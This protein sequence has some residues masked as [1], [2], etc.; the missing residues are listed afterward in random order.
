MPT[1]QEII[2]YYQSSQWLYRLFC[3]NSQS[4]GMHYG[5]WEPDTKNRQQAIVNENDVII[6]YGH[7]KK[8]HRVLDAGCG[9][10]GTAIHIAKTTGARV[11]G[12]TLDSK[13]VALAFHYAK[14]AG[15]AHLVEFFVMDYETMRF[16]D[17]SFDVVYGDESIGYAV[18]KAAFL[19]QAYRVLK[20]GGRLVISDGYAARTPRSS[21]EHATERAIKWGFF[22][23]SI[24]T[25]R[26]MTQAI[27][28][29]GFA[30]VQV[31]DKTQE[32]WPS[33]RYFG[34]LATIVM[35]FAKTL[36][37]APAAYL[38]AIYRNAV[39]LRGVMHSYELGIGQYAVHIGKKPRRPRRSRR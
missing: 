37:L 12:I 28:R 33:V 15:V 7:I 20:P 27:S 32:T 38:Q 18:S 3:Y 5:F 24:M 11:T 29:A 23:P 13:Q 2:C 22:L 9:V 30:N 26:A 35:P 21:A 31:I 25:T 14:E 8:G 19:N 39:A 6:H 34:R 16:P 36:S 17:V 10:G 1:Q 4:L